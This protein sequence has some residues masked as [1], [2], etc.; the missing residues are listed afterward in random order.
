M[1]DECTM[2][3]SKRGRFGGDEGVSLVEAVIALFIA[4][5]V[6]MALAAA[7]MTSLKSTLISRQNQQAS[8]L[9]T[10]LVESTRAMTYGAMTM[11]TADVPNGDSAITGS[12][13][14]G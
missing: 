9:A 11:T 3:W 5:G 8:D 7:A 1:A 12:A 4:T 2:R 6:F 14:L 13:A 10:Q